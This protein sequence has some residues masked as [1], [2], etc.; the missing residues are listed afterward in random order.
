MAI[1]WKKE[2]NL[3][4]RIYLWYMKAGLL[5]LPFA[6]LFATLHIVYHVQNKWVLIAVLAVAVATNY[7]IQ[8][9]PP[10]E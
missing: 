3:C 9:M 2:R 8:G 4:W 7:K 5:A 6:I 10:D 1:D